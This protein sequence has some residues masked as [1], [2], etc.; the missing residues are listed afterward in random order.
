MNKLLIII[1]FILLSALSIDAQD[2][3]TVWTRDLWQLGSQINQVQFT[4][5]GDHIAVAIGGGVYILDKNTGEFV[6]QFNKYMNNC[7]YFTFTPDG[8]KLITSSY[9]ANYVG[10]IIVWDFENNDTIRTI[11]P[12]ILQ[13]PKDI[14]HNLVVG[15]WAKDAMK[16]DSMTVTTFNYETMKLKKLNLVYQQDEGITNLAFD[17][18]KNSNLIAVTIVE[19]YTKKKYAIVFDLITELRVAKF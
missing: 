8:T 4:P 11:F 3:D 14:N 7:Q 19:Q 1:S 2:S 15:I 6:K 5:D 13:L 17:A 9:D 12:L 18:C 10:K 16:M